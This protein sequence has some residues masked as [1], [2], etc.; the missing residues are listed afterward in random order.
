MRDLSNRIPRIRSH[1]ICPLVLAFAV[2]APA[3]NGQSVLGSSQQFGALGAS[4]VTNTGATTIKGNLGVYPG[5]SITG[6]GTITLNGAVHAGNAVAMQ[7]Q[8][9]ALGAYNAL[10]SYA[11]TADLSGMDLGGM[12]LLPGVYFFSSTAQLTGAL[13][14]NFLGN[15]NSQFVFQIGTALTTASNSSVTA[16]NGTSSSGIFWQIG[17]SATLGIGTAFQGNLIADQSITMNAGSTI[18]CGRA[19]ALIAAVTL[20]NNIISNDCRNGGD[21]GTGRDDAGSY[22]F[23]GGLDDGTPTV[24]PEPATFALFIP[25][26][27]VALAGFRRR[28]SQALAR[29]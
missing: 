16:I 20:S 3:S 7:A 9:D 14:L 1:V 12:T 17:S 24:V 28:A 8:F 26:A 4:T 29:A 6:L 10:G 22:G 19:I 18:I 27:M 11:A 23:S 2:L 5:T 13:T 15:A 25:V 21:F